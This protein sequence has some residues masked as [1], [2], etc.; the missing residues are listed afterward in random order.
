MRAGALDE[1]IEF[2]SK[3]APTQDSQ[4]GG[5]VPIW[6]TYDSDYAQ[7]LDVLP[8]RSEGLSAGMTIASGPARVRT[9]YR[10]DID[11]SMRIKRLNTGEVYQIVSPPAMIG[12]EEWT[13]YA[14]EKYSS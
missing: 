7:F 9:R 8:S 14:V 2:Q 11:S 13:E 12:R 3:G 6:P 4:Y 10:G 5:D 1:P